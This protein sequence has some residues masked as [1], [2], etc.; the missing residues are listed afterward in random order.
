MGKITSEK[1]LCKVIARST[2]LTESSAWGIDKEE[3]VIA[4][5]THLTKSSA[6]GIDKE[7]CGNAH[8]RMVAEAMH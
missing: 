2:H 6:W 8:E 3:K 5:S 1:R 4:R 7:E